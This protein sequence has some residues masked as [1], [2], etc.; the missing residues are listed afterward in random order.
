MHDTLDGI[1]R[2]PITSSNLVSIG[3]SPE[4][5]VFAVEFKSGLI[6]HY[7]G[8]SPELASEFYCAGSR[9]SF[10][11]KNIRGKFHAQTM[12]GPC[13]SCGSVS[14]GPIGEVCARCGDDKHYAIEKRDVPAD[15]EVESVNNG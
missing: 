11:S 7:S 4:R 1:S 2:E 12:T 3:Y 5:Q 10:Y 8:I 14:Q 6:I 13:R 9:G 15:V